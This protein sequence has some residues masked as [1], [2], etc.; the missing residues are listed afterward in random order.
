MLKILI[1][2]DEQ[3]ERD[4]LS[5]IIRWNFG[6]QAEVRVADPE[7]SVRHACADLSER[8]GSAG[9]RGGQ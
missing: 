7:Q 1:A 5:D 6:H 9:E 2:D 4:N 8:T 3:M